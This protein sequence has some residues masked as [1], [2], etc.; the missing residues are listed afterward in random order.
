MQ[1]GQEQVLGDLSMILCDPYAV[2]FLCISAIKILNYLINNDGLPRVKNCYFYNNF[3]LLLLFFFKHELCVYMVA[4][5]FIYWQYS[6]KEFFEHDALEFI[7]LTAF[8]LFIKLFW[9]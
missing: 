4:D 8:F 2:N 7:N 5:F 6:Y 1:Q 3:A 9:C